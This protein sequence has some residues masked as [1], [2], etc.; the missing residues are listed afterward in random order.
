MNFINLV[1]FQIQRTKPPESKKDFFVNPC[2]CSPAIVMLAERFNTSI[3]L[4][5]QIYLVPSA[6]LQFR[7]ISCADE[8]LTATANK[9]V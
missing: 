2:Q 1:V 9:I 3:P 8:Q 7:V 5:E 6:K 4:S